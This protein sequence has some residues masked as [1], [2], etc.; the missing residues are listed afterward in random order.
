M[1]YCGQ[2]VNGELVGRGYVAAHEVNAGLHESGQEVDIT[3]KAVELGDDEPSDPNDI[4]AIEQDIAAKRANLER[5][6]ASGPQH[7]A[8]SVQENVSL[9]AALLPQLEA[10][11]QAVAQAQANTVVWPF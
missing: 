2:N 11:A 4:R 8:H 5:Q 3:R 10:A 7:L 1:R 6:L 9:R